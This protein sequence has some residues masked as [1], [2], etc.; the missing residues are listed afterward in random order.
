MYKVK[1]LIPKLLSFLSLPLRKWGEKW[2]LIMADLAKEIKKE[3]ERKSRRPKNPGECYRCGNNNFHHG[4]WNS[5]IHSGNAIGRSGW[6]CYDCGYMVWDRTAEQFIVN[7][8]KCAPHVLLDCVNIP[9][10]FLSFVSTE[11]L[12]KRVV[13]ISNN[14]A[15]K[16]I[17]EK[18]RVTE[19]LAE[20]EELESQGAMKIKAA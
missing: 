10:K 11:L 16:L 8:E 6:R 19:R 9:D 5:G 7:L 2:D 14:K 18:E 20:L 15:N 3:A 4:G 12:E 1:F 17:R 13:R